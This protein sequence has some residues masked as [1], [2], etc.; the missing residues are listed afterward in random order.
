M[1]PATAPIT[2]LQYI[3]AVYLLQNNIP[4]LVLALEDVERAYLSNVKAIGHALRTPRSHARGKTRALVDPA[5]FYLNS[6]ANADSDVCASFIRDFSNYAAGGRPYNTIASHVQMAHL[7]VLGPYG[8]HKTFEFTTDDQFRLGRALQ[9]RGYEESAHTHLT[10]S[11]NPFEKNS[12]AHEV[13][14]RLVLPFVFDSLKSQSLIYSAFEHSLTL[15]TISERKNNKQSKCS[16]LVHDFDTLPL[17]RFASDGR[18]DELDH[19]HGL[20][21]E[22][23]RGLDSY[24]AISEL[25]YESCPSLY[26]VNDVVQTIW[27]REEENVKPPDRYETFPERNGSTPIRVGVVS[28]KIYNHETLKLHGGLLEQLTN[29]ALGTDIDFSIA[30]WMTI[31]DKATRRA[32]EYLTPGMAVNLKHPTQ[33]LEDQ[34]RDYR[35]LEKRNLDVIIY[36]D[37]PL[38][39]KSYSMAHRRI[40]PVQIAIWGHHTY[41]S[42]IPDAIDYMLVPEA[43]AAKGRD[44][45]NLYSEQT[46]L[47]PGM[48]L[49]P[50]LYGAGPKGRLGSVEDSFL[51]KGGRSEFLD[52]FMLPEDCNVY[53][54]PCSA[55]H[56]SPAYDSVLKD[57]LRADPN[58]YVLIGARENVLAEQESPDHVLFMDDVMQHGY[59]TVWSERMKLRMKK[60]IAGG[61]RGGGL[62]RRYVEARERNDA[63]ETTRR[64]QPELTLAS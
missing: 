56:L 12:E 11:S 31:A 1:L 35:A 33:N 21:E 29:K 19:L 46:I 53:V 59:P 58:A 43:F 6:E 52:T 55:P 4:M 16:K 42:Q 3:A 39:A 48:Y 18:V 34:Y 27:K 22:E 57:L 38:D 54:L 36:L 7:C 41:S 30:C 5:T 25:F 28:S 47:L 23:E 8:V 64:A 26:Y 10:H 40:A 32:Q 15:L 24:S 51:S 62:W 44:S 14:S 61:K 63:S 20:M 45:M 17:V 49:G 60:R 2:L 50:E 37:L 9:K 13:Y